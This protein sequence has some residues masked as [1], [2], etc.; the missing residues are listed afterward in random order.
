MPVTTRAK[1]SAFPRATHH[2][3]TVR[4][5]VPH[6]GAAYPPNPVRSQR[7]DTR[8]CA[9]ST[10]CPLGLACT[11]ASPASTAPEPRLLAARAILSH[12]HHIRPQPH[13]HTSPRVRRT[14]THSLTHA[15]T[16]TPL[17]FT[18]LRLTCAPYSLAAHGNFPHPRAPSPARL[19]PNTLRRCPRAR[20]ATQ[21]RRERF[22]ILPAR[23]AATSAATNIARRPHLTS[24]PRLCATPHRSSHHPLPLAPQLSTTPPTHPHTHTHTSPHFTSPARHTLSRVCDVPTNTH[25]R[26]EA[27]TYA[28]PLG[29]GNETRT[30][31]PQT[32]P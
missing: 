25:R 15:Y 5:P 7:T 24:T 21:R 13:L 2:Y 17:H 18:S 30:T 31:Q 14:R 28:S 16:H 32:Q 22:N 6:T 9:R 11:C 27:R 1:Q 23:A 19:A 29:E 3:H 26:I 20:R 4:T 10:A 12:S 8:A